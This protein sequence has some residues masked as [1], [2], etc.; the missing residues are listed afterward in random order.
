MYI[1]N[2]VHLFL[3]RFNLVILRIITACLTQPL[4][5]IGKNKVGK[6]TITN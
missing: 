6:K 2:Q 5:L 4:M 3:F 1:L